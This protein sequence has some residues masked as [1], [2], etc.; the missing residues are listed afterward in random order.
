MPSNV[1]SFPL[2]LHFHK[3]LLILKSVTASLKDCGPVSQQ[4]ISQVSYFENSLF[5]IK[6]L[7]M[8]FAAQEVLY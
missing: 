8:S 4:N 1:G 3:Q 5:R 7:M 6:Q 2:K